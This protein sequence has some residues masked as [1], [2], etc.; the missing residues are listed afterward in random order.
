M[1]RSLALIAVGVAVAVAAAIVIAGM[2]SGGEAAG[3][4]AGDGVAETA[5]PSGHPSIAPDESGEDVEDGDR[6]D[7]SETDAVKRL[8][9]RRD[10]HPDDVTVLLDLGEA[11]FM[12]QRLDEAEQAYSQVLRAEPASTPARVGLAMVWHA[13]GKSGRAE[14]ALHAVLKEHPDDQDAHYS[15]AIVFF[16]DGQIDAAK[17][18]WQMA[19]GIDPT[20][21]TGRRSQSFVDLLDDGQSGSPHSS[22]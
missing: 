8:E 1:R 11:Y 14:E 12:A 10:E 17:E 6:A 5:L 21:V 3:G 2:T 22:D 7:E 4:A 18:E 16:S 15:L 13:Q 19:A 20:T 9:A